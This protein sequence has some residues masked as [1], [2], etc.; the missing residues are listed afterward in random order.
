M[1]GNGQAQ[2]RAGLQT[3]VADAAAN[4]GAVMRAML[5]EV[6]E[7]VRAALLEAIAVL[8]EGYEKVLQAL[9]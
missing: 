2:D 7:S 6:P 9:E 1:N 4:N 5:D 3:T 8:E